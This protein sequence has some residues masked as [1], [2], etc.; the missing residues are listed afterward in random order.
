MILN[1]ILSW[2]LTICFFLNLWRKKEVLPKNGKVE[3]IVLIVDCDSFNHIQPKRI[4]MLWKRH[5]HWETQIIFDDRFLFSIHY[6]IF[7]LFLVSAPSCHFNYGLNWIFNL[8]AV[9]S[10]GLL[11]I[12]IVIWLFASILFYSVM[13]ARLFK[14]HIKICRKLMTWISKCEQ[15][16][17]KKLPL[18]IYR[19]LFWFT[20]LEL[21]N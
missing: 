2:P 15:W 7:L 1:Q 14:K 6:M 17:P 21:Q 16:T 8:F 10:I 11:V 13:G 9:Q 5:I 19:V 20:L 4:F 18:N 3:N 12:I